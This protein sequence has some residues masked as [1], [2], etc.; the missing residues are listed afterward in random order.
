MDKYF[1]G[2]ARGVGQFSLLGNSL[3][4]FVDVKKIKI[5]IVEVVVVI[6]SIFFLM[7][8]LTAM[9]FRSFCFAGNCPPPPRPFQKTL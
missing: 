9:F 6:S 5:M 2:G 4:N 8:L 3:C 1:L 7:A